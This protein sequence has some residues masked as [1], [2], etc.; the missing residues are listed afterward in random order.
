MTRY[1]Q[2]Q[3]KPRILFMAGGTGG[4]IFPALAV[5]EILKEQGW[6]VHWLGSEN[7]MEVELIPKYNIEISL[8]S[9]AGVRGKGF[10]TRLISPLYILRAVWQAIKVINEFKPDVVLG[11]GGFA[12]GPGGLAAWLLRRPLCIHEQNAIAGVTNKILSKLARYSLQAFPGAFEKSDGLTGNP[13]RKSI[14]ELASPEQRF[15]EHHGPIRLLIIGGSRG[16]AIFNQLVPEAIAL[17]PASLEIMVRHQTGKNNRGLVVERYSQRQLI[18]DDYLSVVEFIDD[19]DAAYAWADLVLCRSGALTVS[20][21]AA[22]GLGA[23]F[24]PFPHAV[25]DHQTANASYLVKVKAAEIIQQ[26]AL[27]AGKLAQL[28]NRVC[29][30][31]QCLQMAINARTQGKLKAAEEVAE[32]C[33]KAANIKEQRLAV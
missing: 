1:S 11:M 30:R 4:H 5:A 20:E 2:E 29:N 26:S 13:V 32:F 27:S 15:A 18:N 16:A 6:Q 28:I 17:L 10:L 12:S 8:L 14:C 9:I 3:Q 21:L 23:I 31:K 24:V 22:V 33:I 25:D 7:G 19:M